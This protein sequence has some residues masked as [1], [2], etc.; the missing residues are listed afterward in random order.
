[1]L[2]QSDWKRCWT[3]EE[4]AQILS[5][6]DEECDDIREATYGGRPLGSSQFVQDLE[7]HLDRRLKKRAPGVQKATQQQRRQSATLDRF[8]PRPQLHAGSQ[9]PFFLCPQCFT[10]P[11]MLSL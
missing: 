3:A 11:Q 2:A 1:L 8:S 10:Y 5:S 6:G 9:P 4:W 7:T